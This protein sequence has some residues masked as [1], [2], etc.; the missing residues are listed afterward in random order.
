MRISV[1]ADRCRGHAQCVL[2]APDLFELNDDDR[3]QAVTGLV[4]ASRGQAAARASA[5]CPEGAI[6]RHP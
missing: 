6:A 5:A 3:A 1:D 2:M 4:P